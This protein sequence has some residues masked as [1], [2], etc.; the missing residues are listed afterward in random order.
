MSFKI[1]FILAMAAILFGIAKRFFFFKS[2]RGR[3]GEHFCKIILNSNLV[4]F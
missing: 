4:A 2:G 3:Y 1:T